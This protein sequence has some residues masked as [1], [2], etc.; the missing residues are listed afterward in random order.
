MFVS[1]SIITTVS[2][3]ESTKAWFVAISGDSMKNQCKLF[4]FLW[5][6]KNWCNLEEFIQY[7]EELSL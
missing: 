2:G 4:D 1:R 6:Y 5:D 7:A 3:S